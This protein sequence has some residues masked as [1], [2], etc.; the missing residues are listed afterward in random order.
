MAT[1]S[2]KAGKYELLVSH[3]RQFDKDGKSFVDHVKGDIV[4]LTAEEAERLTS[5]GPDGT[6]IPAV[7]EPGALQH[8]EAE[9][10]QALADQAKAEADA[11]KERAAQA[12]KDATA[13]SKAPASSS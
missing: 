7:G 11:A 10:L 12:V 3:F 9:R 5:R 13:A 4:A 2:A 8:A 6:G 1:E